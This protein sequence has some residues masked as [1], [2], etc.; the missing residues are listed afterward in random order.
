MLKIFYPLAFTTV[1]YSAVGLSRSNELRREETLALGHT[2]AG[3]D[4]FPQ[5]DAA[6][7]LSK[8]LSFFE[9]NGGIN[10]YTMLTG[11]II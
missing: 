4:S 9:G 11:F 3:R 1:Y 8:N 6:L 7:G 5:L 2:G 10:I